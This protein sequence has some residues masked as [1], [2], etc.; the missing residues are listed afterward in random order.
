MTIPFPFLP[1]FGGSYTC[2]IRNWG[3]KALNSPK[4]LVNTVTQP[5]SIRKISILSQNRTRYSTIS[6]FDTKARYFF[7]RKEKFRV[8]ILPK[9]KIWLIENVGNIISFILY[10]MDFW[11]RSKWRLWFFY[12]QIFLFFYRNDLPKCIGKITKSETS[13]NFATLYLFLY[14]MYLIDSEKTH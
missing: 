7:L 3:T 5:F 11:F 1:F 10:E 4:K 14:P 12:S 6:N 2:M 13:E 8:W 9:S